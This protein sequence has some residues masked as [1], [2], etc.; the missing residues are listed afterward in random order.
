MILCEQVGDPR[1]EGVRAASTQTSEGWAD[2]FHWQR[3]SPHLRP[4]PAVQ[5]QRA[6]RAQLAGLARPAPVVVRQQWVSA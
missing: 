5:P 1:E 4:L 6:L 3:K 2:Q